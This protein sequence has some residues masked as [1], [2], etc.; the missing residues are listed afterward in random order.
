MPFFPLQQQLANITCPL[1]SLGQHPNLL[2]GFLVRDIRGRF[3][4]SMAGIL[5][6][7]ITPLAT[8]G[9]YLFVF[10]YIMRIQVTAAETGT[11]RFVVYFLSG[12]FPWLMFAESLTRAVGCL[13]ENA[14]LI[15]KVRF[16]VE[17][18]PAA[19]VLA[20]VVINGTGFAIFL[21]YLL[22][23]GHGN[24]YWLIILIVLPLQVLFTLG[25]AQFLAAIC[26]FIRDIREFLGLFLMI[27]FFSTPIIY[28]LSMVP[29]HLQV[30]MGYN[31]MTL[32]IS[33]YRN[34]L[35][36]QQLDEFNL[37]LAALMA[38]VSYSL[39]AWFFMRAKP[40]FGDVL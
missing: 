2:K 4:G 15:T 28:P 35:L 21:L 9:I 8:M 23:A 18:L 39:G 31:P 37:L 6:T 11:D 32:F 22:M 30:F 27:W 24:V 3:A 1:R 38:G 7:L 17:I 12:L 29:Q 26:V 16:P 5:W 36:L 33:L 20:A 40:A 34:A 13:L 25:I 14:A 19:A 10:S